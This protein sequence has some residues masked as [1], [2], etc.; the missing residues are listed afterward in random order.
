MTYEE[1]QGIGS[2]YGDGA[3]PYGAADGRI[4]ARRL[5]C[6][7]LRPHL[8]GLRRGLEGQC[9]RPQRPDGNERL[10]REIRAGRGRADQR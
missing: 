5:I 9:L 7:A 8:A 10:Q 4:G 1:N 2:D 6:P 3:L